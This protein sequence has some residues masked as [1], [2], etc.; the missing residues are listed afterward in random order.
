VTRGIERARRTRYNTPMLVAAA[1]AVLLPAAEPAYRVGSATNRVAVLPV[2]C[3]RDLDPSL[4]AALGESVSLELAR[5]PKIE[6]VNPNDIDVLL[7]AQTVADLSTCEKDDCFAHQ[8]FT[9]IDAAYLLSLAVGRIG[10]EARLVVRVVDL[11]R[12]AVIDRDEA[13]APAGDEHRIEKAARELS[14][15]VLVRRGL[16]R[17]AAVA[18]DGGVSG[19]FW[20][21]AVSSAVGAVV[22]GTGGALGFA[23]YG[24]TA[25]LRKE[26]PNLTRDDFDRRAADPRA[27]ATGADMLYAA[28]GALVVAGGVMLIAG[29]L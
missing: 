25:A 22:M 1:L 17:P 23:A 10:D 29:A 4:C 14:L 2:R 8:D 19:V 5:D 7:G 12:G 3:E 6:V 18:E 28:G 15:G 24:R 26:A 20:A 13:T 27:W 16:A 21:G 9:R 11:K